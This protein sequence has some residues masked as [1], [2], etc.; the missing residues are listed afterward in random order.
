MMNLVPTDGPTVIE[1]TM[2][3]QLFCLIILNSMHG[4]TPLKYATLI[5]DLVNDKILDVQSCRDPEQTANILTKPLP[6]PNTKDIDVK[7]EWAPQNN[8]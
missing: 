3:A 1:S 2:R 7:W 5:R 4:Q 6:K 8:R